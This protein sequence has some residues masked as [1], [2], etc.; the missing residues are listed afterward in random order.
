M[1]RSNAIVSVELF[2]LTFGFVHPGWTNFPKWASPLLSARRTTS[3]S[4]GHR[5]EKRMRSSFPTK[6]RTLRSSKYSQKN[7]GL[8]NKLGKVLSCGTESSFHCTENPP[9]Y[10]IS[11]KKSSSKACIVIEIGDL[12]WYG[13][14]FPHINLTEPTQEIAGN[15]HL[16]SSFIKRNSFDFHNKL[17]DILTAEPFYPWWSACQPLVFHFIVTFLK[18]ESSTCQSAAWKKMLKLYLQSTQEVV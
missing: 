7:V 5:R 11:I 17:S 18:A 12:F 15:I 16:G 2:L 9:I 6:G 14:A 10:I 4:L 13:L 3:V 1:R 8:N